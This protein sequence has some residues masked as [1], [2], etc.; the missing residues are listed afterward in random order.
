MV[1]RTEEGKAC[2]LD[3]YCPHLGAHLGVGGRVS[4]NC[5]ECPFHGWQFDGRDGQCASIP[6]TAGKSNISHEPLYQLLRLRQR[7]VIYINLSH[8]VPQIARVK[9]WPVDEV[10]GFIF[11]WY[12]AEQ[13]EP[14][15]KIPVIDELQS[16]ASKGKND[17]WLYRGRSDY[18]I[19]A[20]I[21]EIPENGADVA[22]LAHLHGPSLLFGSNLQSVSEKCHEADRFNVDESQSSAM[23][24]HYWTVK[25]AETEDEGTRHIAVANLRQH[26]RLFGRFSFFQTVVEAQQ[27]GPGL[28]HLFIETCMGNCVFIQTVTPIEP[29]IQ[30]VVHRLY[31]APSFPAPAAKL[32]LLG[33]SIMVS[34]HLILLFIRHL[35]IIL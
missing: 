23:L 33:E 20:H 3:A 11:F 10:N 29:L 25:W 13:E 4:G 17:S 12:H 21:Q 8:T 24:R 30:R 28:V 5:I 15:W 22:H 1:F 7:P 32:L 35:V 2:V 16:T 26:F 27:I 9:C 31:T 14:G 34:L 19:N 18:K 6:Y